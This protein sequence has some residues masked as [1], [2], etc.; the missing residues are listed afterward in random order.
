MS[1]EWTDKQCDAA[2]ADALERAAKLYREGKAVGATQR[3]V[4]LATIITGKI[5]KDRY[6]L[7]LEFIG[8]ARDDVNAAVA[9]ISEGKHPHDSLPGRLADC[10]DRREPVCADVAL[11]WIGAKR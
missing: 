7:V 9:A 10:A 8:V 2:T 5:A 3:A 11:E 6:A 1:D 4:D